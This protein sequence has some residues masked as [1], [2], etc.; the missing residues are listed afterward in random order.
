MLAELPL[1]DLPIRYFRHPSYAGFFY[2]ALGTQL[3][4]QN[5]VSFVLFSVLLW[6][7]FYYRTRGTQR[8]V[9]KS[10]DRMLT[11]R[12]I[13]A[14]EKYLIQFFGQEYVAYRGRVGTKIPFIP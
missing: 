10:L 9:P 6:R 7:F 8:L 12:F 4:L 3:V 11:V 1:T 14:E 13:T 2:W 5:P